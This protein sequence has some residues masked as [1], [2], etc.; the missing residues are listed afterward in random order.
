MISA[1]PRRFPLHRPARAACLWRLAAALALPAGSVGARPPPPNPRA[2]A[3]TAYTVEVDEQPVF[4]E[5]FR[6]V[7]FA[8]WPFTGAVE[9]LV[10]AR[11]PIRDFNISPHS[12]GIVA[13]AAGSILRFKLDRPRHLV[14]T[15]NH[16]EKLLLFADPPDPRAPRPGDPGVVSVLDLGVDA[17]GSR[18]ETA[19]LQAAIDRVASAKGTLYFPA[20]IYL[21]GMLSLKSDL[22]LHLA[23]GAR[24]LAS[25]NPADFPVDEGFDEADLKHDPALWVKMGGSDVA[26]RQFILVDNARNVRVSGPGI[27]EGRGRTLRPL[28]NIMF[29]VVRRSSHITFDR[30][31]LLDS[32]MYNV[33][34]LASDHITLRR[35]K[36]VSDQ[37]VHNTDG[38]DPDSSRDVLVQDCFVFTG[39]DCIAIK[40]SGQN[41]LGGDAERITVRNCVLTSRTSG[42]KLGTETFAG[43][44]RDIFFENNDLL[45]ADRAINLSSEDGHGFERIRFI[46]LRVE[47][48]LGRRVQFPVHL[49]VER[50]HPAGAAGRIHDILLQDLSIEHEY[51]TPSRLDGLS[52]EHDV[53]GVRFVNYTV[54]GRVR[55]NAADANVKIGPF[56]SEVTFTAQP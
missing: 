31:T 45:E 43:A 39:D 15:V 35:V 44:H 36:I 13:T 8:A 42:I 54:A 26:Y 53:R 4:T 10:T 56:V 25:D 28:K 40:T 9:V 1:C 49:H 38:I 34:L 30:V 24:L 46:G 21:S 37:E 29:V 47:R 2:A 41:R 17:T 27:I 48:L 18:L 5:K 20:G 6:N 7:S 19:R 55:L 50:R 32:P 3:S 22:T 51:P 11:E 23:A 16:G 52:P 33:H 12:A 14:V